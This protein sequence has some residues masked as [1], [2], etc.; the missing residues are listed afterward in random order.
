MKAVEI[1]AGYFV[2]LSVNAGEALVNSPLAY[3]LSRFPK[4]GA[5]C[6]LQLFLHSRNIPQSHEGWDHPMLFGKRL[7]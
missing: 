5:V 6:K 4:S 7:A 1:T 2:W 3:P